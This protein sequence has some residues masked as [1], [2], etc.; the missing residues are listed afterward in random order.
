MGRV[1]AGR[2]VLKNI[3]LIAGVA[4]LIFAIAATVFLLTRTT[5]LSGE[6]AVPKNSPSG[7]RLASRSMARMPV[8]IPFATIE[9][10]ANEDMP[11][12]F[13]GDLEDPVRRPQVTGD[14]LTWTVKRGD[15]AVGSEG[16]A[17]ARQIRI[18]APLSGT[19][20]LRA[21]VDMGRKGDGEG[22]GN[23]GRLSNLLKLIRFKVDVSGDLGGKLTVYAAPRLHS[24]YRIEPRLSAD[25]QI[26]KAELPIKRLGRVNV[27]R[28]VQLAID[29]S[30]DRFIKTAEKKIAESDVFKKALAQR[31]ERLF[32]VRQVKQ[33]P[34]TWFVFR[35]TA[36]EASQPVVETDAV[37]FGVGVRA[38]TRVIVA[39]KAPENLPTPLPTKLWI[40]D[41]M[42]EGGF[43]LEIPVSLPWPEINRLA[44]D[45]K[46]AKKARVKIDHLSRTHDL[47]IGKIRLQP[48]GDA[49]LLSVDIVART[50]GLLGR[51]QKG[52]LSIVARP[53]MRSGTSILAFT[54]IQYHVRTKDLLTAAASA[55]AA[56]ST[57]YALAAGV[58]VDLAPALE[59]ATNKAREQLRKSLSNLPAGIDLTVD[60]DRLK[61][62]RFVVTQG[63]LNVVM[64]ATGQIGPLTLTPELR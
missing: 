23:A 29:K 7:L 56:K 44:N 64:G 26:S 25:V 6:A 18:A 4:L 48:S 14:R 34:M 42:T 3:G 39:Q 51:Q 40:V 28:P 30:K 33:E 38:E 54:G 36:L 46:F 1:G 31:W 32:I 41:R 57:M 55:L 16:P 53:V 27:R 35:P 49:V 52:T 45:P 12:T 50:G 13:A 47:T 59:K 19:A 62:R 2:G 61:V 9:T 10:I 24:N 60:L 8:R 37:T 11:R 17:N 21:K 43:A 5:T 20:R 63:H 15:V 58:S 22:S